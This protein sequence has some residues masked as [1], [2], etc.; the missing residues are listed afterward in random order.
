MVGKSNSLKWFSKDNYYKD[1]F[2]FTRLKIYP[3]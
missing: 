3:E 1:F 2:D